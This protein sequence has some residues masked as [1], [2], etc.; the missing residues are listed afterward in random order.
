MV[1]SQLDVF[2]VAALHVENVVLKLSEQPFKQPS[3]FEPLGVHSA[4][5][6][7][8]T[9]Y[10]SFVS[11]IN[12]LVDVV[13]DGSARDGDHGSDPEEAPLLQGGL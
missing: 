10:G 1:S 11:A 9:T 6:L 2:S 13:G 12:S 8:S 5:H 4:Q 3:G 7:D